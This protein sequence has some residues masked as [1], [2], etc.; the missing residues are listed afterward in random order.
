[1]GG[2]HLL[3]DLDEQSRCLSF[4]LN[5]MGGGLRLEQFYHLGISNWKARGE[6]RGGE[7]EEEGVG[8]LR[9]T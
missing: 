8:C 1:M 5:K 3:I 4:L 6:G 7:E 9:P 2:A